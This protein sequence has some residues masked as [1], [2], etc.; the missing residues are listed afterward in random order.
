MQS[1]SILIVSVVI[2]V[3]SALLALGEGSVSD[4]P[5]GQVGSELYADE[6]EEYPED[7][8]DPESGSPAGC[9]C[10]L[11][12]CCNFPCVCESGCSSTYC[13]AFCNPGNALCLPECGGDPCN[14]GCNPGP[15]GSGCPDECSAAVCLVARCSNPNCD[16][17]AVGCVCEP[18]CPT[19]RCSP[20]CAGGNACAPG[21]PDECDPYMCSDSPCS[22]PP[23]GAAG[24]SACDGAIQILHGI[25]AC[26]T[27]TRETLGCGVGGAPSCYGGAS[28][29]CAAVTS[30]GGDGER[31][32]CTVP[33]EGSACDS[34]L[35]QTNYV[36][37]EGQCTTILGLLNCG[38][39]SLGVCNL[40]SPCGGIGQRACC[41]GEN[42][43]E[44][45]G[46]GEP[47]DQDTSSGC[48]LSGLDCW[49]D[50]G[51]AESSGM[52]I[53]A[54]CG[55]EHERA[56]CLGETTWGACETGLHEVC[57]DIV[58]AC[59]GECEAELGAGAC[60]CEARTANSWGMC[61]RYPSIDEIRRLKLQNHIDD[62]TPMLNA[63]FIGTHNSFNTS[64][65]GYF[66]P[67]QYATVTQQLDRGAQV[68]NFD[69]HAR[70]IDSYAI[71]CHS[72]ASICGAGDR[73]FLAGLEEVATWLDNNP[74][75][76][77]LL[78]FEDFLNY[79][80]SNSL[81]RSNAVADI[82]S[83]L[84]NRVYS[85]EFHYGVGGNATRT[86]PLDTLTKATVLA[87]GKQIIL[88]TA[89]V[90]TPGSSGT[91]V[92]CPGTGEVC[93]EYNYSHAWR[94]W[95]WHTRIKAFKGDDYDT[96][97]ARFSDRWGFVF[98]DRLTGRWDDAAQLN[99]TEADSAMS[100]GTAVIGF[101]FF[102]FVNRHPSV[103]WSWAPNE[104]NDSGG[105]EDCAEQRSDGLWN[106]M[107]CGLS[108][109]HACFNTSDGT[110]ALSTTAGAWSLG[111]DF[112]DDLGPQYRFAQPINDTSNA[113][114]S[115]LRNGAGLGSV[116]LNWTDQYSEGDW[117]VYDPCPLGDADGD[118]VC[119]P[120]DI[121]PGSDDTVDTDGDGVPDG[122]DQCEGWDDTV[123]TDGDGVPDGCD[124][125][126]SGFPVN[127]S[128][129][130]ALID[131]INC[132][133]ANPDSSTILLGGDITLSAADNVTQGA[134]G[135]PSVSTQIIIE[136]QG[137]VIERDPSAVDPFRIFHVGSAG[138]L[139]IN[140]AT[141]RNGHADPTVPV[142]KRGGGAVMVGAGRLTM[143][144]SVISDN[145][146]VGRGGGILLWG[147]ATVALDTV[148]LTGNVANN[149]GAGGAINC[150]SGGHLTVRNSMFTGN[151]S[152][153]WGGAISLEA[154]NSQATIT[155]TIIAG[156]TA[157]PGGGVYNNGTLIM[158]NSTVAGNR[159]DIGG[160]LHTTVDGDSTSINS[161]LWGNSAP[162]G[163]QINNDGTLNVSFT[164]LEDGVDGIASAGTLNDNG[165]NLS[166]SS[167]DAVFVDPIDAASAPTADGD[168]HLATNSV[169]IDDGSNAA[170]IDAGLITDFEGDDRIIGITVDMGADE[171][172]CSLDGD[173]DG[174]GV[175]NSVDLCPDIDNGADCDSNGVPDCDE[176]ILEGLIGSYYPTSDFTGTPTVRVDPVI[177]FNWGNGEPFPSFGVDNFT[178]RWTGYLRSESA[179]TYNIT[180]LTDDGVR[181][182]VDGQLLIDDWTVHA[183]TYRYATVDL[184]ANTQYAITMEF[185]EAGGGAVAQLLWTPPGGVDVVIPASNL[186]PNLDCD[187]NGVPDDCD[188]DTDGDS[189]PDD[190]DVCPGFDDNVDTDR[191]G[192]A[193]CIDN[194]VDTPNADQADANGDGVGDACTFPPADAHLLL[195][196]KFDESTGANYK[197]EVS[198]LSNAV[199]VAP[200]TEGQ[201]GLAPDW[202]TAFGFTNT[203]PNY[204][205]VEAGT[206]KSDGTYVAGSDP[207]YK[208]LNANWTIAIWFNR[209]SGASTMWGSD[210]DSHDGWSTRIR[211]GQI[212][213]DFGN[214][215]VDSGLIPQ[216]GEDYF[217]AIARRTSDAADLPGTGEVSGDRH[218][219]AL[220]DKAADAWNYSYGAGQ[221]N[222][223]LQGIAIGTFNTNGEWV[224]TLDDPRFYGIVLTQADLDALVM[225]PIPG[226]CDDDGD[227]DLDD[228][229][230]LEACLSGPDGGLGAGC[231]CFDFDDD[232]DNDLKDF[233]AFQQAFTGPLDAPVGACCSPQGAC[234]LNL[235]SDCAAVWLGEGTLCDPNPCGP[236]PPND[237]C[238]NA[239]G[240]G[241]VTNLAFD[242][243]AATFD[244]NGACVTSPNIWYRY[245]AS[246]SGTTTISLFGS[247]YD[248]MLAVYSGSTCATLTLIECNDDAGSSYQSEITFEATAG[249]VYTAEVGGYGT[250]AGAGVLTISCGPGHP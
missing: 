221:A 162:T 177:D 59:A 83:A 153:F 9:W 73:T 68:I 196:W 67:N 207:D 103:I 169:V 109:R 168:Y 154:S 41:L 112:C 21:C 105:A 214:V 213:H 61:D 135:L 158:V 122:C 34:G 64:A 97:V 143:T 194:C 215:P 48:T 101:D 167:S 54:P 85:P 128:T 63:T 217:L 3:C 12:N 206:L 36:L 93:H 124:A 244:G 87:R 57:P 211:G 13:S 47:G 166:L 219:F 15:C 24:Q 139:T 187:S 74:G 242:T 92:V 223:R 75:E 104:P 19:T 210:W 125:D 165:D 131:A 113:E 182:W 134:N 218:V 18:A 51:V 172:T 126:C 11:S 72:A 164:G 148:T 130:Q 70:G 31:A 212:V 247:S 245:T 234:M 203:D 209:A 136:G 58:G 225:E 78:V 117:T 161:V 79:S 99:W 185:F 8:D 183:A 37:T 175:C 250:E 30:C 159:A 114:L 152:A 106:D 186:K 151:Q 5:E 16:P 22:A 243:T 204:S 150:I 230:N 241:D 237:N 82:Y 197:E 146:G 173:N 77:V 111:G 144:N 45:G 227:V 240:I 100:Q 156:N 88:T 123:D 32:C 189:V 17:C 132:A 66:L 94:N 208:V 119:D 26:Q 96:N 249:S 163:S 138:D 200:V 199:E 181:L 155:N 224:G 39:C 191:D 229:V 38:G 120:D 56:C 216:E 184:A 246:C 133:N 198:G 28:G 170:A 157:N 147:S 40:P 98:E 55:G 84:G 81:P 91:P 121:C 102:A 115:A 50:G 2:T 231:R 188:P 86:L 53:P 226:D 4:P 46:C 1:N 228:Y 25:P 71:L 174:D 220:Y 116:W 62:H 233:A 52:C 44:F 201:P 129:A 235:E 35:D 42:G 107:P 33:D 142:D 7:L 20:A 60:V 90:T 76:L 222:M 232:G 190:C 179:G 14:V 236:M 178:I 110:W 10:N 145:N 49:C 6:W 29:W 118:G 193:D 137:H 127:V 80:D 65:N 180:T 149:G 95:V 176:L 248:T 239:Y 202:G 238:E 43:F 192:V 108:Q 23:C 89:D 160:G 195:H 69:V 205:Y 141:L 171:A 27:G 140:E